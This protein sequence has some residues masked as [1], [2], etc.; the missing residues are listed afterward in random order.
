MSD[1]DKL[2]GLVNELQI[3]Q[4]KIE[5]HMEATAKALSRLSETVERSFERASQK[6]G[7]QDVAIAQTKKDVDAVA[8]KVRSHQEYHWRW[9]L[10]ILGA[11][12]TI[13]AVY[14]ILKG[15]RP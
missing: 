8:S 2:W 9:L 1:D 12:T 7:E 3:G 11:P 15:L 4:G 5:V 10:L 14:G 13:I 6:N